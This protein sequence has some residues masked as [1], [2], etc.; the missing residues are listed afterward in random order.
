MN[1]RRPGFSGKRMMHIRSL[2]MAV[3]LAL[4]LPSAR[5]FPA[6][7]IDPFYLKLFQDG[8]VAFVAGDHAKAV[9]DLEVAIFGLSADRTKAAKACIYLGLSH[10]ALKNRDKSRQFLVRAAGLVG[11]EGPGS[12]GLAMAAQNGYE[13]LVED[14][15]I[16][17][18]AP[19]EQTGVVWENAAA[20][21]PVQKTRPPVDSSRVRG[22]ESRLKAS[23]DD[24]A[25][26]YELGS[27]YFEQGAFKKLAGIM[28]GLLK[29]HPE[30]IDAT[31]HLARARFFQR[32]FR[33]ANDGFHK[34]ISPASENQ[35]TKD[36]VLRSTIYLTLCLH[37]LGQK[38][39]LASYLDYVSRNI[40]LAELKRILADEGLAGR[41]ALLKTRNASAG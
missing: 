24:P 34:V 20:E 28:E 14:F 10:N 33:K 41:W 17:P 22:L 7:A 19:E 18:G 11:K 8:E 40:P 31:F 39:S 13:R 36:M 9:K 5:L 15:R 37:E 30:E 26:R 32:E 23:P 4:F 2:A 27:L 25:I 12:L 38:E 29:K 6:Q 1:P 21:F 3:L 16:T 35:I